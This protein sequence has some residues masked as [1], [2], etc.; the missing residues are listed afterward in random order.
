MD[1]GRRSFVRH[2]YGA[3]EGKLWA[4]YPGGT[5][6]E[7]LDVALGFGD[8]EGTLPRTDA[9]TVEKVKSRVDDWPLLV[10]GA[11]GLALMAAGSIGLG[12]DTRAVARHAASG[13]CSA[14][15]CQARAV[16]FGQGSV[17][18][19]AVPGDGG[20]EQDAERCRQ[21]QLDVLSASAALVGRRRSST[22]G[23]DG[24]GQLGPERRSEPA[25]SSWC[26]ATTT[27]TLDFDATSDGA[28]RVRVVEFGL[29][30][31]TDRR[32]WATIRRAASRC[33]TAPRPRRGARPPRW[34]SPRDVI[35]QTG[36]LNEG[37]TRW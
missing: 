26:A 24:D 10:A 14:G 32:R 11:L 16:Q 3:A 20:I 15:S 23:S 29:A 8:K 4:E 35:E 12:W 5:P 2:G 30:R 21:Q 36:N 22:A 7:E 28:T 19:A 1:L 37:V 34:P 9:V 25:T 31:A 33:R 27:P 17:R 6:F 18:V 13:A